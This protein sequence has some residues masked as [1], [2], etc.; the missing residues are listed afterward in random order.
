MLNPYRRAAPRFTRRRNPVQG[1]LF[2]GGASSRDEGLRRLEIATVQGDPEA[3]L[4]LYNEIRRTFGP[5]EGG[6]PFAGDVVGE[7]EGIAE[8]PEGLFY[9]TLNSDTYAY[10]TGG[11]DRNVSSYRL[12]DQLAEFRPWVV[13]RVPLRWN[14]HFFFWPGQGWLPLSPHEEAVKRRG[15]RSMK[16]LLESPYWTGIRVSR[17]DTWQKEP[18]AS[19]EKKLLKLLRELVPPVLEAA[20]S[21]GAAAAGLSQ[22]NHEIHRAE[23]RISEL[24]A[25]LNEEHEKLAQLVVRE[26]RLRLGG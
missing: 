11:D 22:V 14:A 8:T 1:E 16:E 9:W 20:G 5:R 6:S 26:T 19:Q 23:D 2:S 15:S 13:N 18:T 17:T 21:G 10:V 12:R 25:K 7:T 3:A 4:A 24:Q